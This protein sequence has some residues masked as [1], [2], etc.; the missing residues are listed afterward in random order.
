MKPIIIDSFLFNGEIDLLKLRLAELDPIVDLFISVEAEYTFSGVKN[1]FNT[2]LEKKKLIEEIIKPYKHKFIRTGVGGP[3]GSSD[4]WVNE[5]KLRNSLLKSI[6]DKVKE[7]FNW[8]EGDRNVIAMVSD[9]DEIPKRSVIERLHLHCN[10]GPKWF[11]LDTFYYGI[12]MLEDR[13]NWPSNFAFY[14]E[15]SWPSLQK[16]REN[17]F[18]GPHIYSAGWHFSFVMSI[19]E[20]VRKLKSYAHTEYSGDFYTDKERIQEKIN[21][22]DD[23]FDRQTSYKRIELDETFPEVVKENPN[24]WKVLFR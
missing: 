11:V 4:A 12:N 18:G 19:D 13:N 24:K 1:D 2:D 14:L 7:K 8:K 15:D 22:G 6:L 3:W 23:I 20:I 16:M 10:T 9:L 17:R 5:T 21:S